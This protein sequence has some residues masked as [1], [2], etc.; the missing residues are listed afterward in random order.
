MSLVVRKSVIGVSD[1]VRFSHD[2]AHI[3]FWINSNFGKNWTNTTELP[4]LDHPKIP[5]VGYNRD[6]GVSVF[7]GCLQI[8][9]DEFGFQVSDRW[10]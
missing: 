5:K 1:Q 7:F 6:N 4:A 3:L 2:T 8:F 9:F 10:P